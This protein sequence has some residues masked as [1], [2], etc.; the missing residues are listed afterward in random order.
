MVESFTGP[1]DLR[2][3][4]N[5]EGMFPLFIAT[6]MGHTEIVKF[7][8]KH[9]DQLALLNINQRDASGVNCFWVAAYHNQARIMRLLYQHGIDVKIKNDIGS[10]PM[11]IA[12]KKK[13]REALQELIEMGFPI[14]E[15]KQNGVTALGI[16]VHNNDIGTMKVLIKAGADIN[17]VSLK[18]NPG[19]S[20]LSIAVKHKSYK[21]GEVLVKRGAQA[22]YKS[23]P[24]M[25][26]DHSPIFLAIK[27]R[28]QAFLELFCDKFHI[29][30]ASM[31]TSQGLNPLHFAYQMAC[32]DCVSLLS[33]RCQI[34]LL[35]SE[36]PQHETLIMKYLTNV[37]FPGAFKLVDKL[38]QQ[39]ANVNYQNSPPNG[40]TALHICL[41]KRLTDSVNYLLNCKD[42]NPHLED[43]SGKDCCFYFNILPESIKA[44]IDKRAIFQQ[45]DPKNRT[46]FKPK[47]QFE[48]TLKPISELNNRIKGEFSASKLL[49]EY[50]KIR[51]KYTMHK[52]IDDIKP[53]P[54][55]DSSFEQEEERKEKK[56]NQSQL[57]GNQS[58]L[59]SVIQS[60]FPDDK[61]LQQK[62]ITTINNESEPS[63]L[64]QQFTPKIEQNKQKFFPTISQSTM[65][66]NYGDS[67]KTLMED[68]NMQ[69]PES[70]TIFNKNRAK[71]LANEQV[72]LV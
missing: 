53:P 13:N 19:I 4:I 59:I 56:R 48:S 2:F 63:K 5:D 68:L 16:A 43:H 40:K 70:S 25:L 47:S 49:Q 69:F 60:T 51:E 65:Y 34:N 62:L 29:E 30:L 9:K 57:I 33:T 36:D 72:T 54:V 46:P 32:H 38:I 21:A 50:D 45:C 66:H 39:G 11:H 6:F 55:L 42:L 31:V 26:A 35:D 15:E 61:K 20:A 14:D 3:T 64:K 18:Q 7:L 22:Y 10:N 1:L 28:D 8:L 37:K 17:H 27:Q 41:M 12:V 58:S 67:R 52:S 71:Q 23:L 44:K 24:S